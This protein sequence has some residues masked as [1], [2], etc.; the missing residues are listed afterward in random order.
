MLPSL[1]VLLLLRPGSDVS[2]LL[3]LGLRRAV[4]LVRAVVSAFWR[5]AVSHASAC[6][7]RAHPFAAHDAGTVE[8]P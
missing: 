4:A 6:A 2:I 7:M 3:R 8:S 1:G 5:G